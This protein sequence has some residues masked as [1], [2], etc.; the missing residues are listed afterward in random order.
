MPDNDTPGRRL[1]GAQWHGWQEFIKRTTILCYTQNMKALGLVVS[2]TKIIF[3]YVF[4]IV[5]LWK[6]FVA[7]KTTILK[8]SAEK[9]NALNPPTQ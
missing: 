4:R 2:E 8:Q 6:L 3:F 5:S 9:V 7:T 1:Y